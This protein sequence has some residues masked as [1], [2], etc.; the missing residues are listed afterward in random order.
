MSGLNVTA[1]APDRPDEL[2]DRQIDDALVWLTKAAF[3]HRRKRIA[4]SLRFHAALAPI[5]EALLSR[6]GIDGNRRAEQIAVEEFAHLARTYLDHFG[7][8]R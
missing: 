7:T 2:L 3:A 8:Y 1:S 5:S 4:G 6:A